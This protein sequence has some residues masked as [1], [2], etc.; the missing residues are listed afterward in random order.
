[1]SFFNVEIPIFT[2][3]KSAFEIAEMPGL[4]RVHWQ[5]NDRVIYSSF[6]TRH[7]QACLL[8]GTISA[9]VFVMAQFFPWN[10]MTQTLIATALTL[11]GVVGT[12]GLT[13]RFALVERLSWVLGSWILLMLSGAIVTYQGI[14]GSW[15][16][17]LPQICPIWLSL[18]G[19]GYLMTGF[20][21]RS[22]LF[23]LLSLVHLAAIV[24]LPY[25]PAWKP[26]ITG[27]VIS[28]SAFLIA[29][30]QWD[31]NGVCSYPIQT[32][33]HQSQ[34]AIHQDFTSKNPKSENTKLEP[35]LTKRLA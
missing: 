6:Y 19:I 11:V 35:S 2:P 12:V 14:F 16:W 4:W 17:I 18:S 30:F 22:R 32:V 21:M 9:L 31:A 34:F 7:D 27:L 23:L 15:A 3:K 28:G 20:G 24:I 10:W 29:E 5:I 8:W 25:F 33:E 26:F 1:M 13:W